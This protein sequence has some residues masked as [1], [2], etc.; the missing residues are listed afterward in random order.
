MIWRIVILIIIFLVIIPIPL[1][2]ELN[3]NILRLSGRVL[4]KAFKIFNLKVSV[5]FR[6]KYVYITSNNGRTKREKLS[7]KNYNVALVVEMVKQLY[8]RIV[9]AKIIF[10]SNIGY[11]NNS[12]VTAISSVSLDVLSKSVLSKIQHNKKSAHI[13]ISNNAKYN[14][15]CCNAKLEVDSKICLFDIGCSILWALW[16]L[17]GV[18]Y[19]R[20]Q[21]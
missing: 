7:S 20:E 15:D 12:C 14:Q 16:N 3:F 21:E 2:L 17:K 5:R 11:Y 4:V 19:E 10:S 18:K 1:K 9:V 6:G 13:F 8:F